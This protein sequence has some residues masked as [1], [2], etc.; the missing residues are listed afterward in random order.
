MKV[1]VAGSRDFF[2]YDFVENE[3]DYYLG[4]VSEHIEIVSGC[5]AGV[6]QLGIT[7]AKKRKYDI[8]EFPANWA[9]Y[10]KAAGPIRNEEMARY[11]DAAIVFWNGR[12]EKS[13]SYDMIT[14]AMLFNLK[15]RIVRI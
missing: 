14:K 6:D 3:L 8:K 7:Y 12:V 1:I 10:H 13:G 15:L 9:K 11:A 5:C 4:N 2:D